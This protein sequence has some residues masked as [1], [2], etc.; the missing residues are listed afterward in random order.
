MKG[1]VLDDAGRARLRRIDAFGKSLRRKH[2]GTK[3][4]VL[5]N[6]P[7]AVAIRLKGAKP[8]KRRTASKARTT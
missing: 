4:I 2:Q 3:E 7:P 5:G 1:R 8:A 6:L